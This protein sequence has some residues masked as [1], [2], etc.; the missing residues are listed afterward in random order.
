MKDKNVKY[1]G[2]GICVSKPLLNISCYWKENLFHIH[3][4]LCTLQEI[5]QCKYNEV[6]L[7]YM[8]MWLAKKLNSRFQKTWYHIHQQEL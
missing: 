4:C 1:L 7:Y 2:L 6:T 5:F 3:V 8:I